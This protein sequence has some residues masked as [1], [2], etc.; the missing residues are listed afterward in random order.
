MEFSSKK[1]LY[2]IGSSEDFCPAI[3]FLLPLYK[4]RNAAKNTKHNKFA[5]DQI[6]ISHPHDDHISSIKNYY[7]HFYPTL[8][9]T[10][11]D[12]DGLPDKAKVNWELIKN[13]KT[14]YVKYLREEVLP[15]RIPPL[16]SSDYHLDIFYI[17]AK[18]C[19]KSSDLKKENYGNNLTI[20]VYI[21]FNGHKILFMG[22]LMKD[23]SSYLINK[24]SK[25]YNSL[26]NGVDFLITPHHGLR[27]SFP[28]DLFSAMKNGK[29][30]RLN[31]VS[32]KPSS[33]ESRNVDG[34]YSDPDYCGGINNLSSSDKPVYQRKTSNG[35]IYI[36]CRQ[37]E[38]DIKLIR[39]NDELIKEFL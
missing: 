26:Q 1:I 32:E 24:N 18:D 21:Q 11:N 22:D 15:G 12:N 4:K 23:G 3:D 27:S 38:P 17:P 9:T 20:T 39:N 5:M 19:E 2:D 13:R 25:F 30:K 7:K 6:I 16:R 8:L 33:D 37:H 10:P 36:D 35:H 34:R 29:T 31:I 14:E 28:V